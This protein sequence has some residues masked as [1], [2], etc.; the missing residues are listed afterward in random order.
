MPIT[1]NETIKKININ[2][3]VPLFPNAFCQKYIIPLLITRD[4]IL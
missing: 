1:Y 4:L 3:I 2:F